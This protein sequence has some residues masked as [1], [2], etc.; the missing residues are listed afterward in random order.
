MIEF[1]TDE[2]L[3]TIMQYKRQEASG[4]GNHGH[5]CVDIDQLANTIEKKCKIIAAVHLESLGIP[6]IINF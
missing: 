4:K 3:H 2:D 5:V 1:D 6:S